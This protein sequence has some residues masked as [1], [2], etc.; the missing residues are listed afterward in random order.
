MFDW[1]PQKVIQYALS[2]RGV[3]AGFPIIVEGPPLLKKGGGV[4]LLLKKRLL[5]LSPLHCFAQKM[6]I[7]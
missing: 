3:P 4:P 2:K 1:L 6:L 5:H 7:L